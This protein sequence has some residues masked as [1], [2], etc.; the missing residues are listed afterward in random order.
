MCG[1]RFQGDA[2]HTPTGLERGDC[3]SGHKGSGGPHGGRT[4]QGAAWDSPELTLA[5][6]APAHSAH[7]LPRVPPEGQRLKLLLSNGLGVDSAQLRSAPGVTS[8]SGGPAAG[9]AQ[10][11]G[12][13]GQPTAHCPPSQPHRT[14]L[15]P[16][17]M[18][19]QRTTTQNKHP[20]QQTD[21]QQLE[22]ENAANTCCIAANPSP[23]PHSAPWG[24]VGV[25]VWW[26]PSRPG[27]WGSDTC[28][29]PPSWE[30]PWPGPSQS[31]GLAGKVGTPPSGPQCLG[32]RVRAGS[33][34]RA[35]WWASWGRS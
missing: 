12:H 6:R 26:Q 14:A 18:L 27:S 33:G 7:R 11:L 15:L 21:F 35:G 13:W 29:H 23:R 10:G 9:Q 16:S 22:H 20:A 5:P 2:G 34:L 32:A 17:S 4:P 3:P 1:L 31:P 28:P 19:L 25:S 30:P 8:R 24:G